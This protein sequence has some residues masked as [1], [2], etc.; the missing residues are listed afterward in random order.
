VS[1]E[2]KDTIPNACGCDSI[3]TVN[4]TIIDSTTSSINESTCNSYTSPGGKVWTNSGEF[5][6]TIP[7]AA[8]CDSIITVHLTIKNS[9]TSTINQTACG[10][11]TS[12][13]GKIWGNSGEYKDTIPNAAGCDSVITVLLTVSAVDTSV[14][15]NLAVLTSNTAGANYQ[16]INCDNSDVP[17]EGETSQTYAPITTGHYAVIISQ[18]GCVDTSACFSVIITGFVINTFKQNITLYPNPNEG[19]F[20]IDLGRIYPMNFNLL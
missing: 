16:W 6:D 20:T 4:L 13:S 11:Y 1:G 5:K 10:S 7:N 3:I 8:G 19:L 14:T 2:Y 15:Q 9:T 12:P 18:N 17:I